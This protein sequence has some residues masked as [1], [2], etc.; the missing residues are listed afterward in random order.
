MDKQVISWGHSL[1]RKRGKIWRDLERKALKDDPNYFPNFSFGSP[2]KD[3]GKEFFVLCINGDYVGRATATINRSLTGVQ[4][5]QD[6]GFIDDFVVLEEYAD[7]ADLLLERCLS[8]LGERGARQVVA[9]GGGTFPAIQTEGYEQ[10][11]PFFC[12]HNPPWYADIFHRN[13]FLNT[14]EWTFFNCKLPPILPSEVR[15]FEQAYRRLGIKLRPLNIKNR[16][17][18][19][20]FQRLFYETNP[21]S[22]RFSPITI[23]DISPFTAFAYSILYRLF[24]LRM[25]VGIDATGKMVLFI[26]YM[27]D[28]N[29]A[30][31]R[32]HIDMS[33]KRLS[34]AYSFLRLPFV[35]RRTKACRELGIGWVAPTS[36]SPSYFSSYL[37]ACHELGIGAGEERK[38]EES[39]KMEDILTYFGYLM[40][41]DGYEEITAGAQTSNL[42]TQYL[43]QSLI[44]KYGNATP[45][46][47]YATLAYNF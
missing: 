29:L 31:K 30:I 16:R 39:I 35:I 21:Y 17:E 12:P 4:Q 32:S 6:T 13:G 27:P 22:V 37:K 38:G 40:R 41:K 25:F 7:E 15:E 28:L 1:N 33:R 36:S 2:A 3:R 8:S 47:K 18:F 44:Q 19:M 14:D 23:Q 24:K 26:G 10:T 34:N 42:S 45:V 46:G 5:A 43:L 20:E 9:W 11:P